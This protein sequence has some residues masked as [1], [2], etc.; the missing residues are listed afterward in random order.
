MRG[1][2]WGNGAIPGGVTDV[3]LALDAI[4]D[5][6]LGRASWRPDIDPD[7]YQRLA[8]VIDSKIANLVRSYRNRNAKVLDE[9]AEEPG[10]NDR[11]VAQLLQGASSGTFMAKVKSVLTGQPEL[12]EYV[13]A[14]S[15]FETRADIAAVLDIDPSEVTNRQKRVRRAF[16]GLAEQFGVRL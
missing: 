3:D 5:V 4:E 7:P 9:D 14:A 11:E 10:T 2:F 15:V 13:E 8:D 12:I 16:A 1:K 6:L